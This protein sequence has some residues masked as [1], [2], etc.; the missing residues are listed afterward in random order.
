MKK[1]LVQAISD[2]YNDPEARRL[3]DSIERK[4]D[5]GTFDFTEEEEE[6]AL[7]FWEALEAADPTPVEELQRMAEQ[8]LKK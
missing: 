7:A 1:N 2:L 8:F 4:V 5:N 3:L 6:F